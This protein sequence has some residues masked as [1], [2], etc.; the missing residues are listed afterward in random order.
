MIILLI[1]YAMAAIGA[2][3]LRETKNEQALK[4]LYSEIILDDNILN[5]DAL[6][7]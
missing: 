4:N 7:S 6:I 5:L 3:F 2:F 1:M